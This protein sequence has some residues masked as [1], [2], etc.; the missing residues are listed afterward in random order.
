M[1]LLSDTIMCV[2]TYT[3]HRVHELCALKAHDWQQ[4]V[5]SNLSWLCLSMR[6]TQIYRE[7]AEQKREKEE[8]Q[9]ANL[10]KE[11]CAN[12]ASPSPLY[13]HG[14]LRGIIVDYH[15]GRHGRSV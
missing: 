4:G 14:R 12:Y 11:R 8:R 1:T 7:L 5:I 3:S 10:P 9:Q 13:C 2:A 6:N 15:L